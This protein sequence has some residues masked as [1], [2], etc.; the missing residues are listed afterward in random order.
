MNTDKKQIEPTV[1]DLKGYK[2]KQKGIKKI[3]IKPAL[4]IIENQ[5]QVE[6]YRVELKMEDFTCLCPKTGLPDFAT[7]ILQY[8]P[9]KWLLEQKSL[10]L[11]LNA[12][13]KLGIFQE[14]ATNKIFE[15]FLAKTR[16]KWAKVITLWRVRGGIE[17]RVER[18]Y[19]PND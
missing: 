16:P 18:E 12:Y 1:R 5:Y 17:T 4:E 6:N 19:P 9:G 13:R 15:D 14:H 11:Y 10:K 3:K 2:G 8:K 7:I